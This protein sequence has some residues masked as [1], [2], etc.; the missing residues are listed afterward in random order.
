MRT[1]WAEDGPADAPPLVLLHSLGSDRSMWQPQVD[2]L[3]STHRVVR[4]ETRGHGAAPSPP[5]PYTLDDLG[6]DVLD[7]ADALGLDTFHLAGVSL[8]GLVALWVAVHHG[9]RLRSLT[10]ANT[11]ARVGTREGWE[12]RIAQVDAVGR[13]GI[14]DAVLDR[15]FAPGFAQRDPTTYAGAQ[16]AFTAGDDAGYAACCAALAAADLRGE[17]GDIRVPTLVVAGGRDVATPPE[18]AEAL[19]DAIPG[20]ELVVLDGAAHLS[21]LE[22]PDAFTAALRGHVRTAEHLTGR[23]GAP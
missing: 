8:G 4:V 21:N 6:G 18:Q 16:A 17:V 14:R 22:R 9:G 23:T 20:A 5:G 19:R 2:A 1:A 13:A 15:F 11:A 3:R 12:D 7:V 10:A